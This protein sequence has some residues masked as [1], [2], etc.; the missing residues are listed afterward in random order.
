MTNNNPTIEILCGTSWS[1]LAVTP[2]CVPHDLMVWRDVGFEQDRASAHSS[3]VVLP[4]GSGATLATI[5][6][7]GPDCV[8]SFVE[9]HPGLPP[10]TGMGAIPGLGY[11]ETEQ[12]LSDPRTV[13]RFQ[14][15][16]QELFV[17]RDG[18][19]RTCR[20]NG[21]TSTC[22]GAGS[23]SIRPFLA[24]AAQPLIDRGVA[25]HLHVY[26]IG[27]LTFDNIRDGDLLLDVN[28]ASTVLQ[29]LYAFASRNGRDH[30]LTCEATFV[31][32]PPVERNKPLR[33][34]YTATFAQEY[35]SPAVQEICTTAGSNEATSSNL[36]A[37]NIVQGAWFDQIP[38]TVVAGCA[39][40][41]YLPEL[42]EIL[43]LSEQPGAV[44]S[45]GVQ[46]DRT[47]LPASDLD[48]IMRLVRDTDSN[49]GEIFDQIVK[50][51]FD[52][53]CRLTA[54]VSTP[55]GPFRVTGQLDELVGKPF[56]T[57]TELRERKQLLLNLRRA[58]TARLAR[59]SDD[60]R[61]HEANLTKQ[62]SKL[63]K[64]IALNKPHSSLG[65]LVAS[66]FERNSK[67]SWL[68]AQVQSTQKA[69]DDTYRNRA[70]A[71][72]LED[73]LELVVQEIG[74]L[75]NL[76][77]RLVNVFAP[78]RPLGGD[79]RE[80]LVTVVSLDESFGDLRNLEPTNVASNES[81]LA[82]RTKHVTLAGLAHIFACD[83]RI[84]HLAQAIAGG[85]EPAVTG[86]PWGNQ[87]RLNS[88]MR[89]TV[90]PPISHQFLKKLE[91][92]VHRQAPNELIVTSDTAVAGVVAVRLNVATPLSIE[93]NGLGEVITP[94]V[95][96]KIPMARSRGDLNFSSTESLLWHD[97]LNGNGA[98]NKNGESK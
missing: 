19:I 62:K 94:Y 37:I 80:A 67:E 30:L 57:A 27:A 54:H 21:R 46:V 64:Q 51:V 84:E 71:T 88:G 23:L 77:Y 73:L 1:S 63:K 97:K 7:R 81:V 93:D 40:A 39:A 43:D 59:V 35:D 50:P 69:I 66:F 70:A 9:E 86:P 95:R 17:A 20:I 78:F 26:R 56:A 18:H 61:R 13:K 15:L 53:K 34:F 82:R 72:S 52:Y 44:D 29:D 11:L 24:A 87:R 75:D 5:A 22:G 55:R 48:D 33:D 92:E 76:V 42:Q 3:V 98:A 8:R 14:K 10:D 74:R 89:I 49:V 12:F 79:E 36:G 2:D 25:V 28:N 45:L 68:I 91:C 47:P 6:E 96:S 32:M 65:K 90:L 83:P 38:P 58:Y 85:V 4:A 31:E 16:A 60:G 41:E